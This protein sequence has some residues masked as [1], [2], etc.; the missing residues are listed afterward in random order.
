MKRLEKFFLFDE[1]TTI[2]EEQAFKTVEKS[3]NI[4]QFDV[5]LRGSFS[6]NKGAEPVLN[7][8]DVQIPTGK[9]TICAGPVAAVCYF[10]GQPCRPL[11]QITTLHRVKQALYW[12]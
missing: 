9:L 4:G 6:W 11:H 7:N 3:E 8:I 5:T 10:T 12:L 2:D 1:K